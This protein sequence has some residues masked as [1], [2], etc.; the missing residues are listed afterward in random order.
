MIAS[1]F[2]DP[3]SSEQRRGLI[4]GLFNRAREGQ[5]R[6]A[7]DQVGRWA[8]LADD[9]L[10]SMWREYEQEGDRSAAALL[11][12]LGLSRQAVEV[13]FPVLC[14]GLG[15]MPAALLVRLHEG[16]LNQYLCEHGAVK[17]MPEFGSLRLHM[18]AYRLATAGQT[19]QSIHTASAVLSTGAN[20]QG[21]VAFVLERAR[22]GELDR[23]YR[24]P[25][26]G[27]ENLR[28]LVRQAIVAGQSRVYVGVHA[29][30]ADAHLGERQPSAFPRE[31]Q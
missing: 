4:G 7:P 18:T 5:G 29:E 16:A 8:V 6:V 28:D 9:E 1:T 14:P 10:L 30:T 23:E 17:G 31:R 15:E 3:L 27:L 13:V 26:C 21:M 12:R 11:A 24:S 2:L 20:G 25:K 19:M 22:P